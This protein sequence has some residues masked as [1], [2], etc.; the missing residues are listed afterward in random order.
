MTRL[1]A[2]IALAVLVVTGAVALAF[3]DFN[4]PIKIER[5]RQPRFRID[6]DQPWEVSMYKIEFP[7]VGVSETVVQHDGRVVMLRPVYGPNGP[8][9]HETVTFTIPPEARASILES[10]ES[11]GVMKLHRSYDSTGFDG[12]HETL[13]IKQGEREKLVHCGNH[14][15]ESFVNFREELRAIVTPFAANLK[16]HKAD[17]FRQ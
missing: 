15:P 12:I 14:F 4:S 17:P 3:W 5:D 13:V 9:S 10:V 7:S 1:L 2:L 11:N 8:A 6:P 16:W